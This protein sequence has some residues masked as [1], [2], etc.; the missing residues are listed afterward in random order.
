L[1]GFIIKP[2]WNRTCDLADNGF[3]PARL[4]INMIQIA[5]E[6]NSRLVCDF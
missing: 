6:I 3:I 1:G 2:G 4:Q 5:E